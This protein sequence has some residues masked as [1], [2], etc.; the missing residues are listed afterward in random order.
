MRLEGRR[1]HGPVGPP[2]A[3]V[4][5]RECF[6]RCPQGCRV[7]AAQRALGCFGQRHRRLDS[8]RAALEVQL[9]GAF[10]GDGPVAEVG[11]R[12]D[13]AVGDVLGG[14][15]VEGVVDPHDAGAVGLADLA[16]LVAEVLAHL[17][18]EG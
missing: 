14:L 3:I 6:Q 13:P 17:G 11:G 15:V 1:E 9:E 2:L 12:K 16:R 8:L 4:S 10:D 5:G 7:Q 18:E